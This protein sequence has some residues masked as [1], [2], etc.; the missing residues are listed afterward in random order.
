MLTNG[1]E[2]LIYLY[3]SRERFSI[4]TE[5]E[6]TRDAALPDL[7]RPIVAEQPAVDLLLDVDP[8]DREARSEVQLSGQ[9]AAARIKRQM[10]AEM[11]VT[12]EIALGSDPE[13][14]PDPDRDRDME[15][16]R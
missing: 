5:R 1:V 3:G 9:S 11:A 6:A 12:S 8:P 7:E 10:A 2:P 4:Q 16:T 15:M 13:C 14:E